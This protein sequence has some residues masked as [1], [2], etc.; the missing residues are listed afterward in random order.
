MPILTLILFALLL[1]PTSAYAHEGHGDEVFANSPTASGSITLSIDQMKNLGI[2]S[3]EATMIPAQETVEMLAFTELL[4]E[5]QANITARFEGR[6]TALSTKLGDTVQAGQ[7]LMTIEPF[8][9]GSSPVSLSSPIDGVVLQQNAIIGQSATPDKTLMLIGNLGQMLVKGLAYETADIQKLA[10]GQKVE[11]HLSIAPD[12]HLEGTVQRINR[13]I[14]PQTR[15][16]SIYALIDTPLRDVEPGLQGT[17]E[18]MTGDENPVLTVPKQAVLGEM[19]SYFVYVI[20]ARVVE[21]RDVTI[22]AKTG[23]HIEI[24]K[25]VAAGELVVTQ[26]NYQLQYMAATAAAAHSHDEEQD[27]EHT[28]DHEHGNEA[29]HQSHD[30]QE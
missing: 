2:K 26:G 6:V 3:T 13:V 1:C 4:P 20:K 14:D 30:H 12:K 17:M 28:H 9:V 19:G 8:S 16:F 29:E 5:Q 27:A 21:K 7:A 11:I 10:V 18:V 25:G 22:G 24:L 23:D 15:L